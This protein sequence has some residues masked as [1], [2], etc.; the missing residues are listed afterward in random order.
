MPRCRCWAVAAISDLAANVD[1]AGRI[2]IG[3]GYGVLGKLF[4]VMRSDRR[5]TRNRRDNV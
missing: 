4:A 3:E 1:A 5:E 2:Q